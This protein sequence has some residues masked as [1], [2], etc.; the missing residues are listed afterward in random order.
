[1]G[2]EAKNPSGSWSLEEHILRGSKTT[3][4]AN[5]PYVS[6][7]SDIEVARAFNEQGSKLGIAKIDLSKVPVENQL[8]GWEIFPRNS[9]IKGIPYQRS[10]WQQEVSIFQQIPK[11]AIAEVIK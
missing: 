6:T 2:L 10:I 7:T 11:E 1:L 3:A 9:G 4:W 8:K 5:D